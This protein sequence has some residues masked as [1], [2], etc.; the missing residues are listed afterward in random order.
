M[1]FDEKS[2]NQ[3]QHTEEQITR[4]TQEFNELRQKINKTQMVDPTLFWQASIF[5]TTASIVGGTISAAFPLGSKSKIIIGV[6]TAMFAAF[7]AFAPI[8][9]DDGNVR[10]IFADFLDGQIKNY[11][12]T[13]WQMDTATKIRQKLVEDIDKF[14]IPDRF[15]ENILL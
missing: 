11:L 12:I 9:Y 5:C 10:R 6:G 15:K 1:T 2:N 4:F 8:Y 7:A 14:P 3:K 13:N